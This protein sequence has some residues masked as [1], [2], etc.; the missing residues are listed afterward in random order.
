MMGASLAS[1]P[2]ADT[3]VPTGPMAFEGNT[4]R[5]LA[6]ESERQ[7]APREGVSGADGE[8]TGSASTSA[9]GLP[10]LKAEPASTTADASIP[11]VA[12]PSTAAT[13]AAVSS[14]AAASVP[15]GPICM[16]APHL[17]RI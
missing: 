6:S 4:I 13:P 15:S 11:A 2:G 12:A 9:S 16:L 7:D 5:D 3:S 10:A 14:A 1:A 17:L 8:G